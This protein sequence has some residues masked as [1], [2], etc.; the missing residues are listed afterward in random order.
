MLSYQD[1]RYLSE[2][3][4]VIPQR[5][6]VILGKLQQFFI[7][8]TSNKIEHL[9]VRFRKKGGQLDS[10]RTSMNS[11]IIEVFTNDNVRREVLRVLTEELDF[12]VKYVE[13]PYNFYLIKWD[14]LEKVERVTHL[15]N[16]NHNHTLSA[17]ETYVCDTS[18]RSFR[19]YLPRN[20]VN[21]DIINISD[22]AGFFKENRLSV[23]A[24]GASILGQ[25]EI[26]LDV[27]HLAIAFKFVNH[28]NKWVIEN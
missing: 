2:T 7:A 5:A 18:V 28:Q 10:V 6:E 4:N 20:A 15:D 17:G 21:G 12:K 24:N 13:S 1:L 16:R 14:S 23:N 8:A 11:D 25:E 22:S 27:N 26:D 3:S 9:M 19:V